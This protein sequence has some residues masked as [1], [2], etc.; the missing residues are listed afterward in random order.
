MNT[1]N[2]RDASRVCLSAPRAT[3]RYRRRSRRRGA[4]MLKMALLLIPLF[5][6]AAFA[7]DVGW[8]V[9]TKAELQNASDAA[10]LAATRRLGQIHA[11]Y[12]FATGDQRTAL[13]Q[14]ANTAARDDARRVAAANSAGE[15]ASLALDAADVQLS[16]VNAAGNT[17]QSASLFPNA[18]SVRLRRDVSFNGALPLFLAP[19]IGVRES[20]L[21]APSTAVLYSG[22]INR[23]TPGNPAHGGSGSGGG[24]RW[25]FD[26]SGGSRS[27]LA[28]SLLPV[29]F[30]V[31]DWVRFVET[32]RSPNNK[33]CSDVDGSAMINV[34]PS[35]TATPGNFGLLCIGMDSSD[36]TT[37]SRWLLEGPSQADLEFLESSGR[38]PVSVSD[39]KLWIGSPGLKSSLAPD[40]EAIIGQPRLMPLFEPVSRKP[41][42]AALGTG[43]YSQSA[44][45]GFAGVEVTQVVGRGQKL[46][47]YVR[48]CSVIDPSAVF[49]PASIIP[50]GEEPADYLKTFTHPQPRIVR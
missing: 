48:P 1:I 27:G 7:L 18:A 16:F 15:V 25:P 8:I 6:F 21:E 10:A 33:I 31:Q 37:Y 38:F 35:P 32:Q 49:D 20:H 19:L 28:C 40:F 43:T 9:G 41:Y 24:D 46:S 14:E 3:H 5:G 44:I 34:Y 4:I 39:P 42:V 29:T 30:D 17:T 12:L 23:F 13:L 22:Q 47:I 36:A 50:L 26:W 45:V 11:R 2:L